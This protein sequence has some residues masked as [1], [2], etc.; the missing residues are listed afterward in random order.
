[1][2]RIMLEEKLRLR[3]PENRWIRR[4]LTDFQG[5]R[6]DRVYL[7]PE[8]VRRA[9]ANPEKQRE[10]LRQWERS[11]PRAAGEMNRVIA[12][13]RE[14]NPE[15]AEKTD[16]EGFLERMKYAFCAYGFLP[17]EYYN[18]GLFSG[19]EEDYGRFISNKERSDIS[20]RLNDLKAM[21]HFNDK[22]LTYQAFRPYY[23]RECAV[24]EKKR[25]YPG[26]RAFA[27]AH[28]VFFA[29]QVYGFGGH[30][31]ERVDLSS[32]PERIPEVF[33]EIRRKGKHIV[34]EPVRQSAKLA[35]FNESSVNT[36]RFITILTKHGPGTAAC[37][38]RTGRAGAC[39]DNAASGGI[40]AAVDAETGAVTTAAVDEWSRRYE[41]H[42]DSGI[43]FRGYRLPDWEQ[44]VR[45]CGEASI[46]AGEL[47]CLN[48]GWDL[49]HTEEHGWV[50]V[51]GNAGAQLGEQNA[52]R[53]GLRERIAPLLADV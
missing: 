25:D 27:A 41:K 32:C 40:F 9:F 23:R 36:V 45:L 1:M 33:R 46:R 35:E 49:A 2:N 37:F 24:V 38:F 6:Y 28:P 20:Y 30:G 43:A 50:I 19:T 17:Y 51:E 14:V 26:F 12:S 47:G 34:E 8:D 10:L 3:I 13:I 22:W 31:T 53:E 44:L 21:A 15:F 52:T 16:D 48:I 11:Q 7:S 39:V 42:P 5:W 29:K 18:F 4:K